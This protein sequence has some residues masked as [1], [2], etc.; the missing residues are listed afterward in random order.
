LIDEPLFE[1]LH[2]ERTQNKQT[3]SVSHEA[4]Q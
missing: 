1:M 4:S 3:P 2:L